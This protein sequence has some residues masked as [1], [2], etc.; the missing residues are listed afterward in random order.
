MDEHGIR[1]NMYSVKR[2]SST[3]CSINLLPTHKTIHPP[4]F[5]ARQMRDNKLEQEITHIYHHNQEYLEA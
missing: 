2:R 3:G 1:P 4:F 5:S